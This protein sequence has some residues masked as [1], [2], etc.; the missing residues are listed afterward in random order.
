MAPKIKQYVC[1]W[2]YL[3][4]LF[5]EENRFL[6]SKLHLS[7]MLCWVLYL[8]S[9]CAWK[10]QIF[11][12]FLIYKF[13]CEENVGILLEGTSCTVLENGWDYTS[14]PC[15]F[16]KSNINYMLFLFVL[17]LLF[18]KRIFPNFWDVKYMYIGNKFRSIFQHADPNFHHVN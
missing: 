3:C 15:L 18:L 14:I 1:I 9:R 12:I 16:V 13:L 2:E 8:Q 17:L 5:F 11:P 4:N 10:I 7:Y 6:S